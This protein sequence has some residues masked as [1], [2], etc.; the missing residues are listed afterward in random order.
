MADVEENVSETEVSNSGDKQVVRERTS[1]SS[2]QDS[3]MTLSNGVWY[4]VGF[5]EV[6]LAFRL[7]LKM[8]GANPNTGFVEF[9]YS[10]SGV[11]GAPFRGIFSAPTTSGD[12]TTAVFEPSTLVAMVVYALVGWGIVKLI[13]LNRQ[14]P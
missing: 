2:A 11:F 12:V 10:L 8:F 13:N 4:L 7:V 5:I 6:L 1:R 14:N 9:I 3:Q